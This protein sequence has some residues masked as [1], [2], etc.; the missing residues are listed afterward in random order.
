MTSCASKPAP[1][2]QEPTGYAYTGPANLNLRKD[3]GNK[4]GTVGTVQHG[5]RLEVLETRRRFVKVR[6]AQG[7]EGWT[8]AGSLLTQQQVD[9]LN[10]LAE[11]VAHLPSQGAATV[12]DALNVHTA[13]A[14]QAPS[15]A[16][17]PEKGTM[18]VVA[19]R[20]SPRT[21]SS[22]APIKTAS[23]KTSS[24]AAQKKKAAKPEFDLPAPAPPPVPEDLL[25]LSRPRASDLEDFDPVPSKRPLADD[26]YLV[27]MRDGRAGWV[28]ARQALMLIPDEVAQYAEGHTITGYAPLG[29]AIDKDSETKHN[30]WL[31]TTATANLLPYDF[32]SFRV[33]VWSSKKRRYETAYIERNVKGYFPIETLDSDAGEKAF[34][35]VIEDKDGQ[36][37]KRTYAFSGYRVRMTSKMPYE[38]PPALPEVRAVSN[39][40]ATAG[41]VEE[42]HGWSDKLSEWRKRW[43]K[44]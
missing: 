31:W 32:D 37:Y 34:S 19:H 15:F 44:R 10:K 4:A 26:W 18:D 13:P 36:R 9:D 20:V 27:R 39:F 28:L 30:H 1:P 29:E 43:F 7:M 8:D 42:K 22:P 16:Q 38:P 35:V 5:E 11:S 41:P 33:F 25:D 24:K 21:T 6:T 2:R 17:I 12:Y 3:L 23:T 40:D 14:R